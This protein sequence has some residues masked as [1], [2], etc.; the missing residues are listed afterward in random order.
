MK[1]K[2]KQFKPPKH[3]QPFFSFIKKILV[4][5]YRRPELIN[6]NKKISD[7][8]IFVSNHCASRGAVIMELYLPI[9]TAKWGAYQM[10]GNYKSRRTYMRDVF[11]RQ[12]CGYG[13]FLSSFLATFVSIFSIYFYRGMK[14]IPTYQDARFA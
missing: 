4:H 10:L 3:K 6:L 14:F 9:R 5:I 8:A 12:K 1:K 13:K 7:V 2:E 11:Y